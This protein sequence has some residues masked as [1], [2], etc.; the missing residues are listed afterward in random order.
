MPFVPNGFSFLPDSR[1]IFFRAR[2]LSFLFG[3]WLPLGLWLLLLE[4]VSLLE[5]LLVEFLL[6]VGLLLPFGL[7]APFAPLFPFGLLPL[8][9]I[10]DFLSLFFIGFD[11]VEVDASEGWPDVW[12]ADCSEKGLRLDFLDLLNELWI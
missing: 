1:L 7:L 2:F 5:D 6:P 8:E 4:L 11:D 3:L 12:V 9:P 10:F